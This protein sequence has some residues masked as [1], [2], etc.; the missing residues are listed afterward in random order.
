MLLT[1]DLM[2]AEEARGFGFVFDVIEPDA[3]DSR[4]DA[5]CTRVTANAP[6]T[7]Q[8]TREA[9]RRIVSRSFGDDGD[10]SIDVHLVHRAYG[11]RD[12]REGVAAFIAKRTP[13][14]EGRR[15]RSR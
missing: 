1:A 6:I 13:R 11:S 4:L 5:L 12:F 9:V 14:W 15:C 3:F 2:S 10:G 8:V 7:L